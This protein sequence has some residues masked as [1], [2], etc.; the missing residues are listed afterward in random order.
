MDECSQHESR[1]AGVRARRRTTAPTSGVDVQAEIVLAK[2]A[3]ELR[4]PVNAIAGWV[5][6]LRH[7]RPDDETLAKALETIDRNVRLQALLLDDL[8]DYAGMASGKLHLRLQL[9]DLA[10]VAAAAVEAIRPKAYAQGVAIS[11]REP[12]GPAVVCAD[13]SR[14]LQTF[15]NIL[16]NAVKFTPRGGRVELLVDSSSEATIRVLVADTGR[17]IRPEDIGSIF[18]LFEQGSVETSSAREGLGI[19][20]ALVREIVELHG[21]TV[22]AESGGEGLG[23][24]FTVEIPAAERS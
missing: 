19:G 21:G 9:V 5:T 10:E 2:V 17:G 24:T 6:V 8:L 11:M 13:W 14:M 22:S 4:N 1:H 12:A 23:S 20:L 15:G 18:D 7:G 16:T 3:H